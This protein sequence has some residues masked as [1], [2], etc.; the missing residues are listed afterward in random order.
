MLFFRENGVAV[1]NFSPSKG[2]P[3]EFHVGKSVMKRVLT[4]QTPEE[5]KGRV[6]HVAMEVMLGKTIDE[7]SANEDCPPALPRGLERNLEQ[8]WSDDPYKDPER[9]KRDKN[10]GDKEHN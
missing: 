8:C 2:D 1:E 10:S 4:I 7:V 9:E 3:D 6:K 5:R